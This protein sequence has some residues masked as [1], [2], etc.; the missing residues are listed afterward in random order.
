VDEDGLDGFLAGLLRVEAEIFQI[1]E[2]ANAIRT[3]NPVSRTGGP[4]YKAN[5]SPGSAHCG[6]SAAL[7]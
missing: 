1:N 2:G 7:G 5:P 4:G 3:C 6:I